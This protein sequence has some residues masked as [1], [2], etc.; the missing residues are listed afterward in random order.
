MYYAVWASDRPGMLAT[1]MRVRDAHRARLRDPG[2]H[3]VKVVAGGPTLDEADA[4]M[5][6][7]LLVIEADSLGDVR[8]FLAED[9]Y[10]REGVYARVEVRAW[11]WGLGRPAADP[12]P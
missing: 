9:P 8:A 12:E 4:S 10:Q 5:S 2:A 11:Q 6:G 7:S 3:P 1:R